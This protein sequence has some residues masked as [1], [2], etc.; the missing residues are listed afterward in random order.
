[1][2]NHSTVD[3]TRSRKWII[4]AFVAVMAMIVL[5][6]T[7]LAITANDN[8]KRADTAVAEKTSAQAVATTAAA[9]AS[10]GQE[11]AAEVA[12]ACQ[13][14]PLPK[15][16]EPLCQKAQTIAA[17]PPVTITGPSGAAGP[18]GPEGPEG[19]PGPS[20]PAGPQGEPGAPGKDGGTGD[21]GATGND[22]ATGAVGPPGPSGAP[23]S[24][25]AQGAQ[26]IQGP[27]GPAGPSGAAG[28]D[29]KTPTQMTCVLVDVVTQTY[30]CT[31]TAWE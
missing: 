4:I 7:F 3:P 1:M 14:V 31:V 12:E 22:G 24:P 26:G 10:K 21:T 15:S 19:P 9:Q 5:C 20:G 17:Q 13:E 6:A 29:G 27:A 2:S 8:G 23:G 18:S 25:G 28:A 11:L 16:L 30:D